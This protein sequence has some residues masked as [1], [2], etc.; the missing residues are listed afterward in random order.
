[1]NSVNRIIIATALVM[2]CAM[3]CRADP[4]GELDLY[5]TVYG[6]SPEPGKP[7]W[8]MALANAKISQGIG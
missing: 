3:P 4:A 2:A 6:I 1:M 7:I 5:E 8:P